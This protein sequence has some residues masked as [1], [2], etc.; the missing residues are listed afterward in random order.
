VTQQISKQLPAN[1][2]NIFT[3]VNACCTRPPRL[4]LAD[5][6]IQKYYSLSFAKEIASSFFPKKKKKR[7]RKKRKL[8]FV[9]IKKKMMLGCLLGSEEKDRRVLAS[10]G[11]IMSRTFN[12]KNVRVNSKVP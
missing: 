5:C 3:S 12:L 7:K 10:G 6:T 9:F 11:L 8:Q 4:N 2:Q 1:L